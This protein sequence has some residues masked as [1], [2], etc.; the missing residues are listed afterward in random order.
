MTWVEL[1]DKWLTVGTVVTAFYFTVGSISK[2]WA[3]VKV[4]KIRSGLPPDEAQ[5]NRRA[6]NGPR[7]PLLPLS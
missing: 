5:P 4:A 7:G 6:A 2:A 3:D 1:V